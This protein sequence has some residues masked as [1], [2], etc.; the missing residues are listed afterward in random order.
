[1]LEGVKAKRRELNNRVADLIGDQSKGAEII[2]IS[3]RLE[4]LRPRLNAFD[5][6]TQKIVN[7]ERVDFLS[8]QDLGKIQYREQSLLDA[9][10]DSL[11]Y[12]NSLYDQVLADS[13]QL[14]MESLQK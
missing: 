4:V 11:S 2:S 8:E 9:L 7:G 13:D 5:T 1:M 3:K 6:I 12:I 10:I 14:I